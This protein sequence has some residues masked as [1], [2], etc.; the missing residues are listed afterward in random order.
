MGLLNTVKTMLGRGQ[1]EPR[2]TGGRIKLRSWRPELPDPRD[3]RYKLSGAVLPVAVAPLGSR[4]RI[5]DQGYTSSCTGHAATSMLETRLGM[6]GDT[7]QLSRLFPYYLAREIIGE[8]DRDEGAY[9]RDVIKSMVNAGVPKETYWR[10]NSK[11]MLRRPSTSAY[12]HGE[13]FRQ[14]VEARKLVYERITTLEELLDAIANGNPVTFG[15]LAYEH[16][17]G[18]DSLHHLY[19]MP[20]ADERPIGGHAVM[21]DGYSMTDRYVWVQNSWGTRWGKRGYFKMPFEWFTNPAR[22]TDDM[23]TLRPTA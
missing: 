23:W 10:F 4:T 21:A 9:I 13:L 2:G 20:T 19:R 5:H 1:Q 6:T 16:F 14:S 17:Y 3:H 12:H 7:G 11:N 18:L 15:F 8:T 22:L